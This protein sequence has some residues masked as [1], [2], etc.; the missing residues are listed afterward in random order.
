MKKGVSITF[1]ANGLDVHLTKTVD[2][3]LNGFEYP[4]LD[5]GRLFPFIASEIPRFDKFGLLYMV[6]IKL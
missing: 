1:A 6:S 4:L 2:Q 5:L 3:F